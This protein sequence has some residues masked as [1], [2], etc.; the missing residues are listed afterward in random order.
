[1]KNIFKFLVAVFM[2]TTV[3]TGCEKDENRVSYLGGT[4]PVL[5]AN[6]TSVPLSFLT[7]DDEAVK[8]MWTNPEYNFTTGISSQ[9]VNYLVEVEPAG[10]NFSNPKKTFAISKDLSLTLTQNDFNDMLL[11]KLL[12]TPGVPTTVQ[13]RVKSF[14]A[15]N[16][17]ALISNVMVFQVTPYAIPPKVAPPASGELYIVGSATPG[18][19]NNPVPTPSQKFTQIST[20]LYEITLP[21]TAGNSYLFLP[22][23][24]SWSAKY[25][26]LGGNNSNNPNG[27][28]FRD[29]GGDMLSPAAAGNYKIQVDFQRGVFTLTKL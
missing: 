17:V 5:T 19:W 13:I 1:M 24:G 9:D 2:L 29:G 18:S 14:L 8:L 22:V 27:D 16:A 12:L 21:L 10:G 15:A 6:R 28:D 3:F 26:C 11:N 4:A 20:T 23:N 25:G 7:K